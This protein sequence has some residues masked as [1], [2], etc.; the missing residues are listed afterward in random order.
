LHA[1]EG[2]EEADYNTAEYIKKSG[3]VVA[4]LEQQKCIE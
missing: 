4:L 3:I 2:S 1:C